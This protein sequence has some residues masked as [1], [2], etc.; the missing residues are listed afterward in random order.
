M[1]SKTVRDVMTRDVVTVA[2]ATPY[3]DLVDLMLGERIGALPVLDRRR[4]LV[5]IV[6]ETDLLCRAAHADGHPFTLRRVRKDRRR[7]SG[8]SAAAVMSAP[9]LTVAVTDSLPSAARAFARTGVHRL[10][11]VDG[12]R[13]VGIV[14]GRDLLRP[15]LRGDPDICREVAVDVLGKALHADPAMVRASVANGEVL[16]TGRL[17]YQGDVIDAGRLTG[18]VPGVLA[19]HNRLDWHWNGT[20]PQ[21][22]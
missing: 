12:G 22:D 20:R 4:A 11:V 5:G 6:T 1:N 8:L 15:F 2:P 17:E 9:V 3:K 10:C 13:L 7:A 19:V 14:S 18:Q 16:L 21:Q